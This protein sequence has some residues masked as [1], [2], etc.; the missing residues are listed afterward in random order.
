MQF[1]KHQQMDKASI[2]LYLNNYFARVPKYFAFS[3]TSSNIESGWRRSGLH[4]LDEDIMLGSCPKFHDIKDQEEILLI[5]EKFQELVEEVIITKSCSDSQ[6]IERF[7]CL[8][9]TSP[10]ASTDKF[11]INR[12]RALI[13][14]DD[15]TIAMR[16]ELINAAN[17]KKLKSIESQ[18]MKALRKRTNDALAANEINPIIGPP[19]PNTLF[20]CIFCTDSY[21][22][23]INTLETGSLWRKCSTCKENHGWYCGKTK[24]LK[25]LKSHQ[26]L[27]HTNNARK[28]QNPTILNY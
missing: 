1:L 19:P 11:C 26:P 7:E 25:F 20:E 27:C 18:N 4:P 24:C 16:T 15:S 8:G 9:I 22:S 10:I 28:M 6:I 12:R 3:F 2:D 13:L 21:N 17:L 5:K 14:G 23:I